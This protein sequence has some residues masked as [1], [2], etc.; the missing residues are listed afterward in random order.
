M[1]ALRQA[2]CKVVIPAPWGKICSPTCVGEKAGLILSAWVG[3]FV[4]GDGKEDFLILLCRRR[5][6]GDRRRDICSDWATTRLGRL[7]SRPPLSS[8]SAPTVAPSVWPGSTRCTT[9]GRWDSIPLRSPSA[10]ASRNNPKAPAA[11]R[12]H[13]PHRPLPQASCPRSRL[14]F[15]SAKEKLRQHPEPNRFGIFICLRQGKKIQLGFY[16]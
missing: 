14:S 9:V 6:I 7:P 15:P 11:D 16:R 5:S 10:P 3:F 1:Q 13:P 12:H 8:S 4:F 2:Q